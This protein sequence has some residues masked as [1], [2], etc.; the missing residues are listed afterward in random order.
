MKFV[1]TFQHLA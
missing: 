1:Q